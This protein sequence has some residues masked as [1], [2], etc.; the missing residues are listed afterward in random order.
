VSPTQ[1]AAN[2][3]ALSVRWD[4]QAWAALT[5]LAETSAAYWQER[6]RLAWN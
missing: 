5:S 3:G 2:L 6:S 4:D 1:L